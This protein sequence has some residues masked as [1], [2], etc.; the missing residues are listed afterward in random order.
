M[1]AGSPLLLAA[2]TLLAASNAPVSAQTTA[3]KP[4]APAT[5]PTKEQIDDAAFQMRV[6]VGAM[7]SDKVEAPVKDAL[8]EC[9]YQNS[10]SKISEGIAKVIAQN[11]DKIA[12]R[13][14]TQVLT[15]MAGICGYR[16]KPA[17]AAAAP[18]K[19]APAP[20]KPGAKPQGR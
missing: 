13:D 12:K 17:D 6:L 5:Q 9:L 8:F 14:P 7:N 20:A 15:V 16:P 1:R 2:A 11:P 18:A 19:P 3:P 10:F 4:A